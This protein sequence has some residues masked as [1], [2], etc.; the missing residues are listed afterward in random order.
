MTVVALVPAAGR[1]ER[2]AAGRPKAFVTVAGR[3]L[4]EHAVDRLLDAGVDRVVVAVGPDEL[5]EA[6]RLMPSQV[7]VI[8]GGADRMASVAAALVAAGDDA[9]VLLVHDAARAFAPPTMIRRVVDMAR[10]GARAVVPVLPVTDTIR[11]TDDGR[12]SAGL[13]HRDRLRA[14]QTPQGF[15]PDA[16]RA[17]HAA[18]ENGRRPFDRAAITDDA[19]LVETLGGEVV[20]VVG[21]PDAHKITT[22]ADLADAERRW[23]APPAVPA[24]RIGSGV[25]VH[26]I[27]P[28]RPCRLAGLEFDDVDGCAGHSDGDVAAHALADALLA[29]A[30]LG[31]LGGVFGTS[32]PRW[33]GASGVSLLT[34]VTGRL[35]A[36]GFRAAGQPGD[37]ARCDRAIEGLR[38][39]GIHS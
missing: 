26:P 3:S 32:D 37:A 38:L 14:V 28:G 23:G 22:S 19:G 13:V 33:A 15:A 34:E 5:A 21:D 31:D 9:D 17:A 16:L 35:A 30:G 10:S 8:T 12:L 24:V 18:V 25:D 4:L 2:L 29:A 27:E 20:L 39:A 6:R 1:G 11:A 7:S 36:A